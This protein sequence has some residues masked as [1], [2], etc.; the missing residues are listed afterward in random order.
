MDGSSEKRPIQD[1]EDLRRLLVQEFD[2]PA[3]DPAVRA[4]SLK[5]DPAYSPNAVQASR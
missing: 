1:D 4:V 5:A 2:L 3:D